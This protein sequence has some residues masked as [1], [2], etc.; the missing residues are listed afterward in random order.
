MQ[1]RVYCSRWLPLLR[2]EGDFNSYLQQVQPAFNSRTWTDRNISAANTAVVLTDCKVNKGGSA[3]GTTALGK[4]ALTLM[5]KS[6]DSYV[7]VKTISQNCGSYNFGR[8]PSGDY[9]FSIVSINGNWSQNRT[10]FL[11]A[12]V[13]VYY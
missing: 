1:W 4:V 5:R 11:N 8:Q 6:G 9:R 7:G 3:P 2:A 10:T 12:T 13:K